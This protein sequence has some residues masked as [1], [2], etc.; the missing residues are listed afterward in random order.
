MAG[1]LP[2]ESGLFTLVEVET[3]D[4]TVVVA[5]PITTEIRGLTRRDSVEWAK[6]GLHPT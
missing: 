6:G 4:E 1:A 5:V 2:Q 3:A